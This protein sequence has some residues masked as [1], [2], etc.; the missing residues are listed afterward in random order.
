MSASKLIG[1][2]G[3]LDGW[4]DSLWNYF[5]RLQSSNQ[6]NWRVNTDNIWLLM[7]PM[8]PFD[9][10]QFHLTPFNAIWFHFGLFTCY[11]A[12]GPAEQRNGRNW[13]KSTKLHPPTSNGIQETANNPIKDPQE[14]RPTNSSK[15]D[16]S[17]PQKKKGQT[18][19]KERTRNKSWAVW[20]FGNDA[21]TW[22]KR[23][24]IDLIDR[25]S[26]SV[27]FNW[28]NESSYCWGCWNR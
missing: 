22:P 2:K 15:C 19:R 27:S 10:I 21:N 9:S 24:S 23:Q 13:S 4:P 14:W 3:M 5:Q 12:N 20:C 16:N 11:A 28:L 17:L 18:P 25:S 6:E 7:L 1:C 26:G 8:I